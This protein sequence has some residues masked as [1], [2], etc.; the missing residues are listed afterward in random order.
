[1]AWRIIWLRE[2]MLPVKA[3]LSQR[4]RHGEELQ[5]DPQISEGKQLRSKMEN[6]SRKTITNPP[7]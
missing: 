3:S 1:M 2:K 6:T 5:G 7:K 4:N